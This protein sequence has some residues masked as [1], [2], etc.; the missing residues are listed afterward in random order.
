M[1]R[2]TRCN[3]DR[4]M[5]NGTGPWVLHSPAMWQE[6]IN[7]FAID[8]NTVDGLYLSGRELCLLAF[9]NVMLCGNGI[10]SIYFHFMC[11]GFS[12]HPNKTANAINK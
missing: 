6:G 12:L 11:L 8:H 4:F 10:K 1:I 3:K 7:F 9:F 5:P 2:Y